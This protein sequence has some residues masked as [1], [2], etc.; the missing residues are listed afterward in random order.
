[1]QAIMHLQER[2]DEDISLE[3]LANAACFS[4]FHFHRI[5]KAMT[6]ETVMS[7][8]RR[9][10]LERAALKIRYTNHPITDIALSSGYDTPEAFSRAFKRRFGFSPKQYRETS[11]LERSIFLDYK[12][13][14]GETEMD[15]KLVDF[16]DTRV[17]YVRHTGPY[18]ECCGAWESI[19]ASEAVMSTVSENTIMLGLCHDDPDV[20]PTDKI[21]YDACVSIPE[22]FEPPEGIST[23]IVPGGKHAV[24]IHKGS[25][26]GLHDA[27]RLLY[28]KWFPESGL[29]PG[30]TPSFEVYLNSP[31]DTPEDKLVTEIWIPVTQGA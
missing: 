1:M 11:L 4:P 9:L 15:V 10:L 14:T 16:D 7:Y 22:S 24:Y 5:F 6:G 2:L 31:L 8:R 12:Q 23:Q 26:T 28:G 25:Y 29:E 21:R 17:A 19:C 13:L 3:E 27:Y 18:F 20:T 30:K